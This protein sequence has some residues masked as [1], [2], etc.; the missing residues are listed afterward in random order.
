MERI[1]NERLKWLGE[2]PDK[3]LDWLETADPS[4]ISDIASELLAYRESGAMEAI[5]EAREFIENQQLPEKEWVRVLDIT[6]AA[7]AKLE[8]I[9]A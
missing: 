3:A 9:N 7:I 8:A 5:K 6:V 2:S 4:E 1:T